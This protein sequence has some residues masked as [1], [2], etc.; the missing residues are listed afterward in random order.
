MQPFLYGYSIIQLPSLPNIAYVKWCSKT[1]LYMILCGHLLVC[2]YLNVEVFLISRCIASKCCTYLT[3]AKLCE[4]ITLQPPHILDYR[5]FL[6]KHFCFK[7]I[8]PSPLLKLSIIISLF[9][10]IFYVFMEKNPLYIFCVINIFPLCN[11]CFNFFCRTF[12][13]TDNYLWGK[14]R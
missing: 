8:S 9:A 3:S 7:N 14:D 6:Y 10:E 2:I 11:L 4:W 5:T 13:Y 12:Y 1:C